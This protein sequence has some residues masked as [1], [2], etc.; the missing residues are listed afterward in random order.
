V[1]TPPDRICDRNLR[2]IEWCFHHGIV[3]RKLENRD[4]VENHQASNTSL[5]SN[6]TTEIERR[7]RDDITR[8]IEG[9]GEKDYQHV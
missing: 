2:E 6:V 3:T 5:G 9:K 4:E 8:G 1:E 7:F